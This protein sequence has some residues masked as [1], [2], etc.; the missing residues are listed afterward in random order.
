MS[1]SGPFDTEKSSWVEEAKLIEEIQQLIKTKG[2]KLKYTD[3]RDDTHRKEL[4]DL[5]M[6]C[7]SCIA[8]TCMICW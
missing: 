2:L 6:A 5:V 8:C 4:T 3:H 7:P 1:R